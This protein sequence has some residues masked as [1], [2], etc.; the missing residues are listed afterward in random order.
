MPETAQEPPPSPPSSSSPPPSSS[1]PASSPPSSSSPPPPSSPSSP[2]S[3]SPPSSPS[4]SSSPESPPPSESS[5]SWTSL[6]LAGAYGGSFAL[7]ALLV[8]SLFSAPSSSAASSSPV[9][10]IS[11][12][13]LASLSS[14]LGGALSSPPVPAPFS[15]FLRLLSSS[16]IKTVALIPPSPSLILYSPHAGSSASFSSPSL[17]SSLLPSAAPPASVSPAGAE[18]LRAGSLSP[19]FLTRA[20]PGSENEL[21][22]LLMNNQAVELLHVFEEN[23]CSHALDASA[24]I[25]SASS[26]WTALLDELLEVAIAFA[27]L[28]ALSALLFLIDGKRSSAWMRI[29]SLV[30]EMQRCMLYDAVLG[31][32]N[33]GSFPVLYPFTFLVECMFFFR[34][35][36]SLMSFSSSTPASFRLLLGAWT[37]RLPPFFSS[38]FNVGRHCNFLPSLPPGA[39]ASE[40]SREPPAFSRATFADV[41]GHEEAKRQLRQIIHFLKTPHA[42][43]AL[44]ARVPRGVLLEGPSGTGKTLL[45]RA[46]AGEAGV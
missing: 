28:A 1:P 44:G 16:S 4:S 30:Q 11:D 10:L 2:P 42:F 37:L 46:V 45:A 33:C 3:S 13:S 9:S 35:A 22:R 43:D 25:R 8:P 17:L 23:A 39:W 32:S 6:L 41:A 36:C 5:F 34:V 12:A 21:S 18:G 26:V 7:G 14:S 24:S 19:F 20:L 31:R 15:H 29:A 40:G 27:G 38:D